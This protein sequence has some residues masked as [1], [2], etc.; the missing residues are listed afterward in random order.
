MNRT[1]SELE[2]ISD[3]VKKSFGNLSAKQINFKP[4]AK[5][6]SIGQCFEHLI[7]TNNLYFPA[8][9]KVIDGNHRNNIFSE[10]PFATDLIGA[11]MRNSLKPEQVRKMKT[12]KMFEP[13]MSDVS[14]SI[15]NDF[16]ENN[17]KLIELMEACKGLEIHKIK[18]PEPLNVALNLPLDDAFEILAMHE[19]RHFNQ[20]ERVMKNESFPN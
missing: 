8:I 16:A 1:I 6:W 11:L 5:S 2:K 4:S 20:A 17:R 18:I 12:F 7:I 13:S 3:D 15:L 19:Q 14:V 10:I 9:Q